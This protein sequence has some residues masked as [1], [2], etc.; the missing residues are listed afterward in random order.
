MTAQT[1]PTPLPEPDWKAIALE[2][3]QRVNFAISYLDCK[4]AGLL[5]TESGS[6]QNWR[7]YMA[8]GM[9]L[10]P[11]VTVDREILQT[12]HLPKARRKAAQEKIKADRSMKGNV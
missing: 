11:G 1:E 8:D 2:L 9:E 12:L 3:G 4:G 7:D 5:N 6:I 10:I